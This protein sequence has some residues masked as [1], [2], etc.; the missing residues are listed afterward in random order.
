MDGLS[1]IYWVHGP[2][3]G[4]SSVDESSDCRAPLGISV[5]KLAAESVL[6]SRGFHACYVAQSL[7][8]AIH[9]GHIST[10]EDVGS[11][12]LLPFPPWPRTVRRL[13][14]TDANSSVCNRRI[15][16][17]QHVEMCGTRGVHVSRSNGHP[18]GRLNP[19]LH[20]TSHV[21]YGKS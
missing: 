17:V 18:L 9:N 2:P 21:L 7:A 19:T 13:K 3:K 6:V 4:C 10:V 11:V 12:H 8:L 16:T 1:E 5:R 14:D 15:D 20:T